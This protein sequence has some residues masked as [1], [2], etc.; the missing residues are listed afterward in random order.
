MKNH[1]KIFLVCLALASGL[2]FADSILK[3][4]DVNPGYNKVTVIWET[5]EETGIKG[6]ELQR[7]LTETSFSRLTYMD[8]KNDNQSSHKYEYEDMSVFKTSTAGA[9]T[10]YY[11]IKIEKTDGSFELSAVEKVVPTVSSARQTWGSIKAM[12]R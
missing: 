7:G 2:L 3:R 12:F 6:Y 4:F 5:A 1:L 9:R 11:R 8:C 10:Y